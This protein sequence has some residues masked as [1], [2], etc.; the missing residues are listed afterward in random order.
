MKLA[1]V[2]K[3]ELNKKRKR[4]SYSE[5]SDADIKLIGAHVKKD[6]L[7]DGRSSSFIKFDDENKT[8]KIVSCANGGHLS[9][10][11]YK[12]DSVLA[13]LKSEGFKLTRCGKTIIIQLPD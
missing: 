6:C 7:I 9:S 1:N 8:S 13:Y 10:P 5:L 2:I 12:R 4:A 11:P 3:L